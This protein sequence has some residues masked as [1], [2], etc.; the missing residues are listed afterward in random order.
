MAQELC[1]EVRFLAGHYHGAEWPPGPARIFQALLAG[2][3]A[4]EAGGRPKKA[5]EAALH[6]LECLAPPLIEAGPVTRG[7]RYLRYVPNNDFD[8]TLGEDP[9]AASAAR[10]E[11]LIAPRY[12]GAVGP[13][14]HLRYRWRLPAD[15]EGVPHIATLREVAGR[16]YSLGWGVDMAAVAL[17]EEETSAGAELR[18]VWEPA[19][20]GWLALRVAVPGYI[21]DLS[22]AHDLFLGRSS[23]LG[24]NPDTQAKR[25]G[26][27]KYRLSGAP[28]RPFVAFS[29]KTFAGRPFSVDPSDAIVVAAWLRH[30]SGELL[31][32]EP[33]WPK[34]RVNSYILGHVERGMEGNRISYL[35]IPTIGHQ[36][37]DGRIRRA[38]VIEPP[39]GEGDALK[40]LELK[41]PG[42]RL[43]TEDGIA[44][45]RV[46]DCD[47]DDYVLS[48]MVGVGARW[49]S[50]TPVVLHG[51]NIVH[52]RLALKK[53]E[54][55]ILGAFG[56][57]GYPESMIETLR[58][59]PAPFWPG[60]MAAFRYRLP[61][62]LRRFPRYHIEVVFRADVKGPV[63]AGIG[64]HCGLGT[65][66]LA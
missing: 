47:A 34:E 30:S 13:V 39:N 58:F 60:G 18:S 50:L 49:R 28:V 41:L 48:R 56:R 42:T 62:H 8:K 9:C 5:H 35:P 31:S 61:E 26:L 32:T 40:A 4:G 64:R 57:A 3:A 16:V 66:A 53:T 10:T 43:T 11:K 2:A 63:V 20:D 36:K 38:L 17:R 1:L 23:V 37:A 45:C 52:G 44:I 24:V 65:F 12:V 46:E 29:L 7:V 19:R 22:T 27:Q 55:L 59:Q 51:R 33:K 6:W 25:Y 14:P 21:G 15:G 54:S